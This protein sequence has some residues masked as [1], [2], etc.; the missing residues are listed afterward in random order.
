MRLKSADLSS[1]RERLGII[2]YLIVIFSNM[3]AS[4]K[5][6]LSKHMGGSVQ[7]KTLVD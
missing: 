6:A 7:H 5:C 1:D 3:P 2:K 4:S